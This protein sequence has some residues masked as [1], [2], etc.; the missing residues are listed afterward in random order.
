MFV[1]VHGL[2][3]ARSL[4]TEM[5]HRPQGTC[6]TPSVVAAFR[7]RS[8]AEGAVHR[9]RESE[10][11]TREVRL[12]DST[13]DVTNVGALEVDELVSG[14]FFG[15]AHHL[16]DQLLGT[17]PDEKQATDYDDMVRREATLV[18]VEVDSAAAARQVCDFLREQGAERVATLPQPGLES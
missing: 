15:N 10:L 4:P 7:D 12:H 11:Q 13:P 2:A 17:R 3:R 1:K 14:G 8:A 9:L 6:M 5:L 18:S 16:L